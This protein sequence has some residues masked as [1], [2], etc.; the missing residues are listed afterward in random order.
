MAEGRTAGI[1]PP[2]EPSVQSFENRLA[3]QPVAYSTTV[4]SLFS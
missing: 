3:S 1:C 2:A 4:V